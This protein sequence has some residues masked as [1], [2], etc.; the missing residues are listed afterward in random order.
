MNENA[1]KIHILGI[2]RKMS[3]KKGIEIEIDTDLFEAGI[4]D[5]FNMILLI[6]TLESDFGID[7]KFEELI[8]QNLWSVEAIEKFVI[9]C[10]KA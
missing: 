5:S 2:L 8:P 1:I 6:T 10:K 7:I 9:N 4:L 3:E